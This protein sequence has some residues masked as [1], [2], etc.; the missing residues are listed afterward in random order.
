MEILSCIGVPCHPLPR[1]E[2]SNRKLLRVALKVPVRRENWTRIA[3]THGAD[4]EIRV[5]PL[6][7]VRTA[8]AEVSRGRLV[9]SPIDRKARKASRSFRACLGSRTP[10]RTSWRT[11]PMSTAWPAA[12]ISAT[13]AAKT[14]SL[15]GLRKTSDQPGVSM[16]TFTLISFDAACSRSQDRSQSCHVASEPAVDAGARRILAERA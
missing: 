8:R 4:Q 12:I 16:M 6:N 5:G 2:E 3:H 15:D 7:P 11:G 1:L 13:V 10:L 14:D 9:V